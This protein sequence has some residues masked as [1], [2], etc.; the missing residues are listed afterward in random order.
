MR[1]ETGKNGESNRKEA[2]E[3]ETGETDNRKEETTQKSVDYGGPE[4][5][6]EWGQEHY[7]TILNTSNTL[8]NSNH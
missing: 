4:V 6:A 2:R 1:K 8:K 3:K 5:S 7:N